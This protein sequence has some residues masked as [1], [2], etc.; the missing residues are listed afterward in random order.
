M[1]PENMLFLDGKSSMHQIILLQTLRSCGSHYMT[2]RFFSVQNFEKSD[3]T[4]KFIWQF[5]DR[6]YLKVH[7]IHQLGDLGSQNINKRLVDLF[8]VWL[9]VGL[10]LVKNR[11]KHGMYI[12]VHVPV[13]TNDKQF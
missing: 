5:C 4:W 6:L 7:E 11:H 8:P 9:V 12:F 13:V 3:A 2:C 10:D 1:T